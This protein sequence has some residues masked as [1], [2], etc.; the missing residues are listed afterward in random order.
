[1]RSI[2][3]SSISFKIGCWLFRRIYI[4]HRPKGKILRFNITKKK[5]NQKSLELVIVMD[6]HKLKI[7]RDQAKCL[8]KENGKLEA[9][10]RS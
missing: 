6:V 1:M 5:K 8:E 10:L 9:K 7:A 3:L 4:I 2:E